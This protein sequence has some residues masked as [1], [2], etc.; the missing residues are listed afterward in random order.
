MSVV[1]F[2]LSFSIASLTLLASHELIRVSA[3]ERAVDTIIHSAA[4]EASLSS[5]FHIAEGTFNGDGRTES[6]FETKLKDL[7][8]SGVRDPVLHWS[9]FTPKNGHENSTIISVRSYTQG[10]TEK[11]PFRSFQFSANICVSTWLDTIIATISDHR[12]CLGQY[13]TSSHRDGAPS[14]GIL[15]SFAVTRTVPHWV[16][17]YYVGFIHD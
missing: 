17:T 14:R 1:E 7:I 10:P 12:D 13:T 2:I 16:P 8:V 11:N 6:K 9:F 15:M 5:L 4:S 3:L